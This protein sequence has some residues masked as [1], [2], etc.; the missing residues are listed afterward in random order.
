MS[1]RKLGI[2]HSIRFF[3]LEELDKFKLSKTL[4][5]KNIEI[6]KNEKLSMEE[7]VYVQYYELKQKG[8]FN[9]D[10]LTTSQLKQLGD[11]CAW[12]VLPSG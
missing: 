12:R 6:N 4:G 3:D 8:E 9:G 7:E 5:I 11:Y 10:V 1:K 2:L